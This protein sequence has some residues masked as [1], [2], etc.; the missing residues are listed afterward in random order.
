[1]NLNFL[2]PNEVKLKTNVGEQCYENQNL[3]KPC[4]PNGFERKKTSRVRD[5]KME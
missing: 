2:V 1:M 4:N 5:R 3:K